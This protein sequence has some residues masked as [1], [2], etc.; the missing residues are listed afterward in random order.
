DLSMGSVVGLASIL[1]GLLLKAH[2]HPA[3]AVAAV[4]SAAVLIGLG[5]G[6]LV[7][8][9]QL[10]PFIVTLCGLFIYRGLSYW[11]SLEEPMAPVHGLLRFL[12]L[13]HLYGDVQPTG[14]ALN[15]GIGEV[16][17][18]V[19]GLVF[20]STGFP[21]VPFLSAVPVRLWLLLGL[22]LLAAVLMHK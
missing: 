19:P 6:L 8:R 22:A 15:V 18:E 16:S 14:S 20:L 17:S 2:V 11:L 9:L 21:D 5:H 3:L 13:G 10:Q 4:L 7:T 12:S 1:L